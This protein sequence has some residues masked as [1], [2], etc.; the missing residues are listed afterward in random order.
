LESTCNKAIVFEEV[1]DVN[2]T[3]YKLIK[4]LREGGYTRPQEL[5]HMVVKGA[6]VSL[7]LYTFL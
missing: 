3:E 7:V 4:G 1:T 5:D 6:A 2:A